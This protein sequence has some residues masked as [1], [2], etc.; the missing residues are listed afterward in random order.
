MKLLER[1]LFTALLRN[2]FLA[3]LAFSFLFLVFDFLDRI[4]NL[5]EAGA[6][7]ATSLSYFILKLPMTFTLMLP[8]SLLVATLFT[9]GILTKNGEITAMRAAGTPLRTI[10]KPFFWCGLLAS[11]VAL[12]VSETV[13]PYATRR[14]KEIYHIDIK[15]RDQS[16]GFSADHVWWREANSFYLVSNFDSRT[17]TLHGFSR[18]DL[19]DSFRITRR[20]DASKVTW[21]DPELGWT[22]HSVRQYRFREGKP[23]ERL[24]HPTLPLPI[25]DQPSD[26]YDI[27]SDPDTMSFRELRSFISQQQ[28]NG[29]STEQ[30]AADLYNKLSFHFINLII[31]LVVLPIVIRPGRTKNIA[32]GFIGGLLIGF[33]YYGVHSFSL[34]LGRAEL[35][36]PLLAAWT[37]NLLFGCIAVILN[38][39]AES[40]S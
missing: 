35:L 16:G 36:P 32:F 5:I 8:V 14:V 1:Y 38:L 12:V 6:A 29:I 13:V 23:V 25:P 9:V 30:Y 40:P 34:A 31:P 19:S 7:V 11:L 27:K 2:V 39:G 28:R 21:I 4:D 10:A 18:F 20:L 3:L 33:A 37:A 17:N 22:M 26:F 24:L 15:Q